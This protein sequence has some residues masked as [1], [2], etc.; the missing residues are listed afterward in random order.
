MSLF[1]STHAPDGHFLRGMIVFGGL[2]AGGSVAKG[3]IFDPPD[4]ANAAISELN[5]FQNQLALLLASLGDHQRLQ[6]QWFCDSDY[7]QELLDYHDETQKAT[8]VWTRRVRNERFTRY[9]TAM[10]ERQLRRQRLVIWIS[11]K[12]EVSPG[13]AITR[14]ALTRHYEH[15]LDQ[16]HQEFTQVGEM[17]DGIFSGHDR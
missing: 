9:W 12:I 2:R 5:A 6:V 17:L 1:D 13:L 4:L 10:T 15:L 7:R 14:S 3:F 8:N 16:L 11:R